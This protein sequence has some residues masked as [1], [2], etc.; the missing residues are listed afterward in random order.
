MTFRKFGLRAAAITAA[1]TLSLP[2]FAE[3]YKAV[4]PEIAALIGQISK[5]R[6]A[7][8]LKKL[9]GFGTRDTHSAT[10]DS[11]RGIGA[12]RNW[13][14]SELKGY[15][16]R[17]QVRFDSY[18][19]KKQGR[20]QR[21][22]DIVNVVAVLPGTD[23]PARQTILSAHYDSLVIVRKKDT[24]PDAP[25]AIDWAASSQQ[26]IAPG[27]SDDGSGV[28]AVM[29]I[30]RV[31][32]QK[33]WRNTL[34]FVLFAAEEQGLMGSR[35]FATK[36][37]DANINIE[38]VLNSDIIG[39]DTA[40][41]GVVNTNTLRVFS[42]DPDDSNSRAL[43]RF[44]REMGQRYVPS[45]QVDL[46]ARHDRFARGGDHTPFAQRGYAAVRFT[47]A[48]ENYANQHSLTDT[49]AN[50]SPDYITRVARVKLAAA[51]CL[52][53][54]PKMPELTKP[55][56]ANSERGPVIP[57]ITRGKSQ[58]DAVLKWQDD[59]AKSVEGYAVLVRR[60]T[61]PDWEREI[62]VGNTHEYTL[63]DFSIDDVVI[64]V[65]AITTDGFESPVAAYKAVER[66]D[67]KIEL[68]E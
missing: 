40:G 20:I 3:S 48:A 61:A 67:R 24:A 12:A 18:K 17:L 56:P 42:N 64:G 15:S 52:A 38:A 7:G 10:D 41:N 4:N 63:K 8:N 58:Y 44:I 16:D 26:P 22:L 60:T 33:K 43:A 11:N 57:L 55:A 30:A 45:M 23:E 50:A 2:G 66:P 47:T 53:M 39:N 27:V 31:M 32:S 54:S 59:T 21:D 35:L 49:F 51:A 68:V 36:A 6:V 28:A 65:K 5:D 19:I 29:E 25:D 14:A 37:K 62:Y 13:I 9:E 34:V 1:L 46:I